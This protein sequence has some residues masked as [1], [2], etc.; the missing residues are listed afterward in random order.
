MLLLL[1]LCIAGTSYNRE[2]GI[3]IK[4]VEIICGE[5]SINL[6]EELFQKNRASSVIASDIARESTI[7]NMAMEN[8]PKKQPLSS[9][10]KL[11]T[12]FP[13]KVRVCAMR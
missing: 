2:F 10:T 5:V 4:D 7:D 13:E 11:S 3:V 6:N 8:L 9:M 1:I 12:F